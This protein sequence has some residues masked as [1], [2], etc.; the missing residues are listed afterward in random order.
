MGKPPQ[1]FTIHPGQLSLLHSVGREMV[2]CDDALRL[3]SKGR[4]G[5]F[6]LWI[7]PVGGR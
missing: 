2:M 7:K 4:H 3:G 1:Y 5:S 6:N